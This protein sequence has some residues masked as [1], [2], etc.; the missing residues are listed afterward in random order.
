MCKDFH[1]RDMYFV[2]WTRAVPRQLK[3]RGW[4]AKSIARVWQVNGRQTQAPSPRTHSVCPAA[5]A[6]S[7]WM[8]QLT[9]LRKHLRRR[10]VLACT[11]PVHGASGLKLLAPP[12]KTPNAR[13]VVPDFTVTKR[14]QTEHLRMRQTCAHA[15]L[16]VLK[17][18]IPTSQAIVPV[19]SNALLA[20]MDVTKK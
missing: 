13:L 16:S 19:S 1:Q 14:P 4:F 12:L 2:S 3:P 15:I 20:P 17:A 8:R 5:A 6:D 7:G 9:K 11:R 18:N 10:R